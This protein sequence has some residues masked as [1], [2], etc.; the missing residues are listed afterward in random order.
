MDPGW[1]LFEYS[2]N[3]CFVG[4][5]SW[6]CKNGE[7]AFFFPPRIQEHGAQPTAPLP[8]ISTNWFMYLWI[9]E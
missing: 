7:G 8:Y 3:S 6:G 2:G 1:S 9:G 5:I 4:S